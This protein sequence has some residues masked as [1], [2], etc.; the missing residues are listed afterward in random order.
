MTRVRLIDFA[1]RRF[2]KASEIGGVNVKYL[3]VK[4]KSCDSDSS[5]RDLTSMT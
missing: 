2:V 5:Y 3:E 4:V 1:E